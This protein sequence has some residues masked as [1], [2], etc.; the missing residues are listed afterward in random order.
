MLRIAPKPTSG[1]SA[2]AGLPLAVWLRNF[3]MLRL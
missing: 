1:V 3:S 2:A